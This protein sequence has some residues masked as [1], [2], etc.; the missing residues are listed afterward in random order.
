VGRV[1]EVGPAVQTGRLGTNRALAGLTAGSSCP[2]DRC[3]SLEGFPGRSAVGGGSVRWPAGPSGVRHAGRRRAGRIVPIIPRSSGIGS[4]VVAL[5]LSLRRSGLRTGARRRGRADRTPD[6]CRWIKDEKREA[7]QRPECGGLPPATV[8][9][10]PERSFRE[11][12]L[13]ASRLE[14]ARPCR[15]RPCFP[16]RGARLPLARRPASPAREGHG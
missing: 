10:A 16:C 12:T 8:L 6:C 5:G 13:G 14:L 2:R 4:R 1:A 11:P 15:A 7:N 3:H 9:R